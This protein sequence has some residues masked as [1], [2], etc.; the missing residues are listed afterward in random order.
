MS[1][2]SLSCFYYDLSLAS[3]LSPV[4]SI[5]WPSFHRAES[6]TRPLEQG[7][8]R[9]DLCPPHPGLNFDEF[10]IL[11]LILLR[12]PVYIGLEY[13]EYELWKRLLRAP[14]SEEQT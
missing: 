7:P 12:K 13:K 5:I 11:N 10:S 2:Y 9:V 14:T 8:G 6:L 3:P 1:P 4:A